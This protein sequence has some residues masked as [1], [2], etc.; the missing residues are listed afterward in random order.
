MDSINDIISSLSSED[1]EMLKGVASSILGG[2]NSEQDNSSNQNSNNQAN[3]QNNMQNNLM[4]LLNNGSNNNNNNNSNS[5]NFNNNSNSNSQNNN[6]LGLSISDF[7]MILKA[8]N[9]FE[10]MN[11]KSS[12]NADLIIALK[13]HLSAKSQDKADQAI[14]MLQ[15]FEILPYLK[16][17]F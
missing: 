16:E 14:K 12:K 1:I 2:E 11:S 10:K 17:L 7:N 13:P 3:N 5:N 4:S 6:P 15:L 8:K 9:I